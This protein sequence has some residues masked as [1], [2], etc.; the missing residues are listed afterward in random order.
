MLTGKGKDPEAGVGPPVGVAAG[1]V[2]GAEGVVVVVAVA[3]IDVIV[4]VVPLNDAVPHAVEALPND[5]VKLMAEAT[6]TEK[7]E[8]TVDEEGVDPSEVGGGV[9]Q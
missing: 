9:T 1:L 4:I 7:V 6:V 8:A 2:A 5:V 3:V